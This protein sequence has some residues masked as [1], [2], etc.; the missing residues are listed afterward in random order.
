MKDL[1]R[2]CPKCSREIDYLRSDTPRNLI[3]HLSLDTQGD[4]QYENV[5]FGLDEDSTYYCPECGRFLFSE[6]EEAIAFLKGK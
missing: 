5:D 4:I 1:K 3:Q 2:I 6:E